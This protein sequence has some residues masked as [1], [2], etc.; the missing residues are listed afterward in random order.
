LGGALL[1]KDSALNDYQLKSLGLRSVRLHF[2][3][4]A[5]FFTLPFSKMVF[6][7]TSPPQVQKKRCVLLEVRAFFDICAMAFSLQDGTEYT[8]D[9]PRVNNCA[10]PKVD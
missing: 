8:H 2:S 3:H 10:V 4:S 7:L 1:E 9:T 6:I 5:T